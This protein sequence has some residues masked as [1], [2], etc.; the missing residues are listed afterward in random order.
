M[1]KTWVTYQT[2]VCSSLQ[3]FGIDMSS[4]P[5]PC[6]ECHNGHMIKPFPVHSYD[7]NTEGWVPNYCDCCGLCNDVTEIIIPKG[8]KTRISNRCIKHILSVLCNK[9]FSFNY[10]IKNIV[11]E[12]LKQEGNYCPYELARSIILKLKT[13]KVKLDFDFVINTIYDSYN[14]NS[15]T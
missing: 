10:K 11:Y 13:E 1:G 5:Q 2:K 14:V 7:F 8:V 9:G 12:K 15:F 4:T 3:P 6:Y